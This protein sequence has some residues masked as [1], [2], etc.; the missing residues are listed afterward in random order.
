MID[1]V[2][3]VLSVGATVLTVWGLVAARR[4]RAP[5]R[6]MLWTGAGLELLLLG[7]AA[8]AVVLMATGSGP[9]GSTV[10]FVSYLATVVCVLPLAVWWASAERDR[11][12]SAVVAVAAFTVAA[13]VLRLWDVWRGGVQI[14]GPGG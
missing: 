1:A 13:M 4:G 11:W 5:G 9:V 12:S 10:L 7:Q 6:A 2:V 8:V 3:L 14:G